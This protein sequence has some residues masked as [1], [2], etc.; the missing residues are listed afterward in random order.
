MT[1]IKPLGYLLLCYVAL[2]ASHLTAYQLGKQ[3]ARGELALLYVRV[4]EAARVDGAITS[5][6]DDWERDLRT[7]HQRLAS[8]S[9]RRR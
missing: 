2:L 3:A 1:W 9:L 5:L 6:L 4:N 7:C 8:Y